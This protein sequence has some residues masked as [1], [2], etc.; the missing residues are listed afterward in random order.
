M[1]RRV[2][3][4]PGPL[5]LRLSHVHGWSVGSQQL[6]CPAACSSKNSKKSHVSSEASKHSILSHSHEGAE[7]RTP[8]DPNV[9]ANDA[10]PR[11]R[12]RAF[13]PG[14]RE[15]HAACGCGRAELGARS[16]LEGVSQCWFIHNAL[17]AERRL[18]PLLRPCNPRAT[19]H[20]RL[21]RAVG[22]RCSTVPSEQWGEHGS[23]RRAHACG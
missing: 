20:V 13:F 19:A 1:A 2:R 9:Y 7:I 18:R 12:S 21:E 16:A 3:S 10:D 4:V 17:R 8:E 5:N 6:A 15:D 11:S 22:P 14:A 23:T